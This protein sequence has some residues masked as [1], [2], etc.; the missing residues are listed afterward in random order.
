MH[1]LHSDFAITTESNNQEP[2]KRQNKV[3]QRSRQRHQRHA[4]FPAFQIARINWYWFCPTKHR[5]IHKI[6]HTFP[7]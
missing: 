4:P 6:Q 7:V 5:R 2:D 3:H 1:E